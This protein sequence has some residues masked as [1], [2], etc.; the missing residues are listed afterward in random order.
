[1]KIPGHPL[2]HGVTTNKLDMNGKYRMSGAVAP[3]AQLVAEW[4]DGVPLAAIRMVG[5]GVVVSF[6]FVAKGG[7]GAEMQMVWNAL[8]L[9]GSKN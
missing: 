1:M 9:V 8:M 3:G 7:R 6:S 2:V 5:G 4:S